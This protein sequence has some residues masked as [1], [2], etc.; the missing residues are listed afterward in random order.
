MPENKWKSN[1]VS[2][3]LPLEYEIAKILVTKGF[4]VE[5]DYTYARDSETGRSKDFSVDINATGF[6]PFDDPN[7]VEG[8]LELLVECKH[9][10]RGT[11]WLFLPDV[12]KPGFSKIY[13][14]CALHAYDDFSAFAVD[15]TSA[16]DFTKRTPCCYKGIEVQHVG[17]VFDTEIRH[18]IEQLRFALP[19]LMV[20]TM[21][22]NMMG[23]AEDNRPF[24][25]CPILLTNAELFV[26]NKTLTVASVEAADDPAELGN[27]VPYLI[28]YSGYGPDFEAHCTKEANVLKGYAEHQ[29]VQ[30]IDAYREAFADEF[31][32]KRGPV[33]FMNGMA[34][35]DDTTLQLHF[36]QFVVCTKEGFG[37]LIEKM[38]QIAAQVIDSKSRHT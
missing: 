36:T 15:K 13:L 10:V 12:N 19:R 33:D 14:G 25:V 35:A 3:S 28:T 26:L 17:G 31:Y 23:H 34:T 4:A 16:Y 22:N 7:S 8:T 30:E 5:A 32:K 37:R 24:L 2:S 27:P 38:K 1:L 20:N 29:K 11:K 18:G 6:P 9:R 21:L